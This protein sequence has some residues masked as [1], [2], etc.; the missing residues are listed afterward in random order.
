[1]SWV[2]YDIFEAYHTLHMTSVIIHESDFNQMHVILKAKEDVSP[3]T[4]FL[5]TWRS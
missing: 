1:M 3:Y 2:T 5:W 4:I